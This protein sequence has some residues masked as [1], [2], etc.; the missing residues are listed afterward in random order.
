MPQPS[1]LTPT[2][3][4]AHER[5]TPRV[6]AL[7]KQVERSAARHPEHPVPAATRDMSRNLFGEGRKILG[8]EAGRLA[9]GATGDLSGLALAL[10]QL[11]AGL[12]AFEAE[13]SSFSFELRSVAWDVPGPKLVVSRLKPHGLVKGFPPVNPKKTAD[14]ENFRAKLTRRIDQ[15]ANERY[16]EGYRDAQAGKP[17]HKPF[18]NYE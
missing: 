6:T 12:M 8:R 5:L 7:L 17:P 16:L 9:R 14:R 3:A 4:L 15:I 11:Q 1:T 2:I 13:H 10:G 18:F